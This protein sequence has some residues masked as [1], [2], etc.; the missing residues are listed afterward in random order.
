MLDVL[1]TE[2]ECAQSAL[3]TGDYEASAIISDSDARIV[4]AVRVIAYSS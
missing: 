2:I 3:F 1:Y 4:Y